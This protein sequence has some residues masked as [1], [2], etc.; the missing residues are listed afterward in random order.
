M[1][2][3]VRVFGGLE[4]LIPGARFGQGIPL[5]V[6][7]GCSVGLLLNRLAIPREKVFTM[8]VNGCHVTADAILKE[9]DRISLFPAIGGG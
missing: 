6:Q 7:E 3:E 1:D 9:G 5:E 8:L 2:V 4:N